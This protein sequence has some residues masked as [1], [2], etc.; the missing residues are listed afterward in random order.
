MTKEKKKNKQEGEI[1]RVMNKWKRREAG[2]DLILLHLLMMKKKKKK[3]TNKKVDA[4]EEN[5]KDE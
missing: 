3:K 5:K 1:W 4:K 2:V